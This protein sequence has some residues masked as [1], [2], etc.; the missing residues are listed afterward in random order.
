MKDYLKAARIYYLKLYNEVVGLSKNAPIGAFDSGV[1]GLSILLEVRRMLP[2]ED[3]IYLADSAH[4]PYGNKPVEEIRQRSLEVT[5]FL[6]SQGVK[7]VIVACN[8][9]CVAGL[10]QVRAKYGQV[11][12]VGVEPAIKPAHELTR[13]GKVGVLATN[14]TLKGERFSILV[15]KYATGVEVYTQPAPGLVEIVEAGDIETPETERLLRKYLQPLLEKGIDTLVLGCT[16][17]P[18]LLPVAR[19]ICG[20]EVTILDTGSAVA[21]QT[22]R[23]LKLANLTL[24]RPT[25]GKEIFYT[26]GDP[27]SV[28]GVIRKLWGNDQAKVEKAGI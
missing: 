12:I 8:S 2:A 7:L 28:T 1:G 23:V 6:V 11:P 15:E 4:C 26:S 18:F 27:A 10:D 25:L 5:D 16:H 21:K 24:D 19:R 13:N 22:A 17:Y 20:P 9:A 3:L 14:L